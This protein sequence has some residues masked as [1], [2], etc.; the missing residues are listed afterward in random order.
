MAEADFDRTPNLLTTF[1][2][3][4]LYDVDGWTDRLDEITAPA[5]IIHGTDDPVLPF[6]H[7]LAL[8]AALRD[9]KMLA[10]DGAGHELHRSDW[11][12][13]LDAIACHTAP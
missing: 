6:A 11:P 12:M 7:G 5:L 9:S 13:I 1:N 4:Q 8:H 3:A 2:H 10:L